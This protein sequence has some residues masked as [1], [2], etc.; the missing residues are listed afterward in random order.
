MQAVEKASQQGTKAHWWKPVAAFA[1]AASLVLAV[2]IWPS[3]TEDMPTGELLDLELIAADDSL[4]LYE[5]LDFYQWLA[6]TQD[7]A[8]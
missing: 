4:Q 1:V 5:E 6:E 8:G 3:G 2:I 7:S